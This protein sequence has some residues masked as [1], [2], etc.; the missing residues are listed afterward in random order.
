MDRIK[1]FDTRQIKGKA[2]QVI[3][4]ATAEAL[5]SFCDQEPEFE[6]AIEQSGKSFADCLNE[7]TKDV[8][9]SNAGVSDIEVYRR[10]VKFYFSTATVSFVMRIDLSGGNGA[11]ATESAAPKLAVLSVSLDELLDF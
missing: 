3:A 5:K 7:I 11:I 2:Q 4:S 1:Y 9:A 6:Q 8:S 10:A